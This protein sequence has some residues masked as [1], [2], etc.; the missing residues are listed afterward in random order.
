M[1]AIRMHK[2]AI[3]LAMEAITLSHLR[4]TLFGI[5]IALRNLNLHRCVAQRYALWHHDCTAQSQL[6][7]LCC[8]EVRHLAS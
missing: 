6:S 7:S 2:E 8:S 5:M 4:C 1:E 3:N